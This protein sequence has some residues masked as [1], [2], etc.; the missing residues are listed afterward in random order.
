M[1]IATL[2][3]SLEELKSLV[4]L[5]RE[6]HFCGKV[7]LLSLV[8]SEA[9]SRLNSNPA[10]HRRFREYASPALELDHGLKDQALIAAARSALIEER[11]DLV[12]WPCS[13]YLREGLGALLKA[14]GIA[15]YVLDEKADES[16][17]S[18]LD[19]LQAL[20]EDRDPVTPRTFGADRF[21]ESHWE[22]LGNTLTSPCYLQTTP[23]L[24]R[25]CRERIPGI[26]FVTEPDPDKEYPCGLSLLGSSFAEKPEEKLRP[27]LERCEKAYSLEPV[28]SPISGA[29]FNFCYGDYDSE[30]ALAKPDFDLRD[31]L[32]EG[33]TTRIWGG[34]SGQ[35]GT[36]KVPHSD[37]KYPA[38]FTR[39]GLAEADWTDQ[40]QIP[41]GEE[42]KIVFADSQN[43]A[44]SVIHH[45][46]AVNQFTDCKAWAVAGEAHP[47]IGPR[48]SNDEVFYIKNSS[49]PSE[50]L[51]KVLEEADCFVFF[52]DDDESSLNWPFPLAPFV[53]G[54][55][56]VHLYIGYRV[57]AKTPHLC[58]PGRTILT[59]LPHI[60]KMYPNSLFY[61]GFPPHL[62]E[63]EEESKPESAI[64]GICR[65]LHTPSLPHWTTCRYP[66]HKDTDAF[67]RAA[68]NLKKKYP[69]KVEFHQI[70]GWNH[71]EVIQARK[72]CDVTFN[73]LRGFHGLSGDE[74]M[75][76][77][78]ICVQHFDQYN[79][80][81]HR[82][83]WGLEA[84]FPWVSCCRG[85]LEKVFEQ[86]LLSTELRE[87]IGTR[88]RAFMMKYFSPQKGILPLLYHCY[89]AARR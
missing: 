76:L 17:G 69:S 37:E 59:P 80:N 57:H 65:F 53:E 77:G 38:F 47:F 33:H 56:I 84:D 82:E 42:I 32:G 12:I 51:K 20:D 43:V 54:K 74:A 75:S 44:C 45:A 7:E 36:A 6:L 40:Y 88:S 16:A 11:P 64:D 85:T 15:E 2:T 29:R 62:P 87:D 35:A 49:Q 18:M 23:Q 46:R 9:E 8:N 61:A 24:E 27:L 67:L 78:R 28:N 10:I 70:A 31:A 39:W 41:S 48:D 52:E 13:G 50:E 4:P 58:R 63:A 81:R 71:K 89:R 21:L 60:L 22:N 72:R 30:F 68:R 34:R 14:L 66:Y 5:L 79:I 86:L 26:D 3:I 25:L 19:H 1:K 55:A 83:Y 73:Q